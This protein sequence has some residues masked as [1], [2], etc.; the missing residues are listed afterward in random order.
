MTPGDPIDPPGPATAGTPRPAPTVEPLP[1]ADAGAAVGAEIAPGPPGRTA[2]PCPPGQGPPAEG[3]GDPG[4]LLRRFPVEGGERPRPAV[5]AAPA[6]VGGRP[7]DQHRLAVSGPGPEGGD[8]IVTRAAD[9]PR[10]RPRPG[11]ARRRHRAGA[12]DRPPRRA[13]SPVQHPPLG[14]PAARAPARSP[15]G[16][17]EVGYVLTGTVEL[18][19]D[20]R[21]WVPGRRRF[22]PFRFR[23]AARLSQRGRR[24]GRHSLG[25]TRRR[26]S[27]RRR[28]RSN[29]VPV[30]DCVRG[31]SLDSPFQR[32]ETAPCAL[33]R[34][35]RSHAVP[36]GRKNRRRGSLF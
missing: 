19:V 9:R 3:S 23:P 24:A 31:K 16:G 12:G 27:D 1:P 14:P 18:S 22:L 4:R 34:E 15:I 30:R 2:A 10:I 21:S 6:P 33:R 36:A 13:P 28:N 35:L 5:A 20:G 7:G 11:A 17:E 25:S 8:A 29:A 26:P 32:L